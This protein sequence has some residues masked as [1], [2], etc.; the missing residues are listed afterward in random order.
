MRSSIE[1]QRLTRPGDTVASPARRDALRSP[2]HA[3]GMAAKIL[4][5]Q[6]TLGNQAV[7]QRA[8]TCPA[9]PSACPTGG[10][11]HTCPARVQAKLTVGQPG[12]MYE[13]EADRVAEAAMRMPVPV[14]PVSSNS[15][16]FA[17]RHQII[18][19]TNQADLSNTSLHGAKPAARSPIS[20]L[21]LL[22]LRQAMGNHAFGHFMQAKAMPGRTPEIA[23]TRAAIPPVIQLQ[24]DPRPPEDIMEA[25]RRAGLLELVELPGAAEEIGDT[26]EGIASIE[27]GTPFGTSK[28][29]VE[30]E[31][32]PA[33]SPV[34]AK[35]AHS[36]F[37]SHEVISP[38]T[39]LNKLDSGS[40]MDRDLKRDM[41]G[42]CG[43][44]F[45]T[46]KLHTGQ[47]ANSLAASLGTEAFTIGT[48]IAFAEGKFQPGTVEGR[49]LIAHELTHVVQQRRGISGDLQ[50]RGIGHPG[51]EYEVEADH[52]AEQ[53]SLAAKSRS[54]D[55]P[56]AKAGSSSAMQGESVA[57]KNAI[58][59]FSGSAAAAY[60]RTWATGSNPAYGRFGN[61]CTNFA[62]QAMEAGGW[63]MLVGGGYCADRT[64]DSVWWFKRDGCDRTWPI[65][66]VHASHTWGGAHNFYN[67]V[68]ASVRGAAVSRVADLNV[69]DV[70][71]MDF[72]GGGHIGH[73][74]IVT[75][76][77]ATN[78]FFSYHTSD[79][80]D[81]PF[82]PHGTNPGILARN[83]D[84]P[85]KYHGWNM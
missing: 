77:N 7:Q 35:P 18:S 81:E 30:E 78:L 1:R 59:L 40:P 62:S 48:N 28:K 61:D 36:P 25:R 11:C 22:Q 17:M 14:L 49:K 41:E 68:K 76:K 50:Q 10:A 56:V 64:K 9:F 45:G 58:Q 6:Q 20:I 72:S 5:M 46:V 26:G 73:T 51:D 70:L 12:D 54:M 42:F 66:N 3:E 60:A 34:Q 27:A 38:R 57:M 21:P 80:L 13:Q 33:S 29:A 32:T 74:M 44:R 69:G 71:Q 75:Q 24:T 52:M 39:V 65:P 55:L 31:E 83:P 79:H 19:K 23:A 85:T 4:G 8:S 2:S 37:G 15:S 16:D 43:E 82:W 47:R 67:F 84:P 53:V 63:T